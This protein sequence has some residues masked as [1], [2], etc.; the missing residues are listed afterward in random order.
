MDNIFEAILSFIVKVMLGLLSACLFLLI[1]ATSIGIPV[2]TLYL[3]Y[4][5][6]TGQ[7]SIHIH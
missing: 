5:T 3:I 7:L 6:A 1:I 4:K 2:G